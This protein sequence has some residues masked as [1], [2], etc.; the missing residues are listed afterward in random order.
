MCLL[1]LSWVSA[2]ADD[3][4]DGT[5]DDDG[6]A[7]G[8]GTPSDAVLEG[9]AGVYGLQLVSE[10]ATAEVLSD[11]GLSDETTTYTTELVGLVTMENEGATLSLSMQPCRATLPEI[12]GRQPVID[13]ALLASM[14]PI[15]VD[16]VAGV[17]DAEALHMTTRPSVMVLGLDLANPSADPLPRDEDDPAVFD[18]DQD[19]EPGITVDVSGWEIYV[20]VRATFEVEG[21]FDADGRVAGAC[22]LDLESEIYGDSIPFFDARSAVEESAEE[23]EVV[24]QDDRFVLIPI[25]ESLASC[26]GLLSSSVFD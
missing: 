5:W 19:G 12:D 26:D 8:W 10:V 11:G 15:A 3:G 24:S 4:L 14:A 18:Q 2:C 1:A 7:D 20:G 25:E 17:D 13:D 6:K 22:T 21:E 16:G 9:I 23:T